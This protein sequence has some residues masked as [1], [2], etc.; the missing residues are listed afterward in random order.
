MLGD[1]Q[2]LERVL[3]EMLRVLCKV[4]IEHSEE[5]RIQGTVCIT[6]DKRGVF[7][8]QLNETV[9]ADS[10][11]NAQSPGHSV[12]K[13][14]YNELPRVPLV[15]RDDDANAMRIHCVNDNCNSDSDEQ[16]DGALHAMF[17]GMLSEGATSR[18]LPTDPINSHAA[19]KPSR[20]GVF[21][22]NTLVPIDQ[23]ESVQVNKFS[24]LPLAFDCGS[25][26]QNVDD[27]HSKLCKRDASQYENGDN[28]VDA[29]ESE[30]NDCKVLQAQKKVID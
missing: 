21:Q 27:L 14:E 7:V 1:Q 28:Y 10:D 5:I 19:T 2:R 20:L 8:V 6:V 3:R 18:D 22:A 30:N 23:L 26:G 12:I 25:T 9:I 16:D 15:F 24:L 4:S 29:A 11:C 13:S 17:N